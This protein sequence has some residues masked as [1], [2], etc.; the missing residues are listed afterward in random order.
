M[1]EYKIAYVSEGLAVAE[2]SELEVVV[3]DLVREPEYMVLM[4]SDVTGLAW[5]TWIHLSGFENPLQLVKPLL[6][7]EGDKVPAA[8]Y[9][10]VMK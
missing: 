2:P 6:R 1:A 9:R 7:K 5:P 10:E 8:L 4:H 3:T